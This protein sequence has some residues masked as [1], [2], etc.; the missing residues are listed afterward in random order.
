METSRRHQ[1]LQRASV[2]HGVSIAERL[3]HV[4]L[5]LDM[6]GAAILLSSGGFPSGTSA[7]SGPLGMDLAQLE[8]TLGE[9]PGHR[10]INTRG[11]VLADQ[12]L[13]GP[14]EEWPLFASEA[15]GRGIGSSY[16]FPLCLGSICVGV[17]EVCR[18]KAGKLSVS[19]LTDLS[20][21]ASLATS[22]LLLMQSGLEESDLLDLLELGDPTQLRIHQ[23]TGMV[24]QQSH[25]TLPNALALMRAYGISNNLTLAQV[26]ELVVTR[27]IRME[28]T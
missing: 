16:A 15:S 20:L 3:C 7:I 12:L 14:S 10:S 21:L 1:L 25:A 19:D 26:A 9:G 6:D 4:A 5:D 11:P 17:F 22:A 2:A 18:H 23:A 13:T 8:L 24:A 27:E 28:T